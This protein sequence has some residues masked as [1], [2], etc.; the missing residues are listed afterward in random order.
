MAHSDGNLKILEI[1]ANEGICSATKFKCLCGK[2][3]RTIQAINI[4]YKIV[5][6]KCFP[7]TYLVECWFQSDALS[8]M[9]FVINAPFYLTLLEAFLVRTFFFQ[10]ISTGV[11]KIYQIFVINTYYLIEALLYH[12]LYCRNMGILYFRYI[13]ITRQTW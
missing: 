4:C 1:N 7:A 9:Y 5:I 10:C 3:K 6:D 13:G 8:N 2:N 11:S 12:E